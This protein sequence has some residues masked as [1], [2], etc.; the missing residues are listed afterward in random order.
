L[1]DGTP[2]LRAFGQGTAAA[3]DKAI[4]LAAAMSADVMVSQ[5]TRLPA[6]VSST[7]VLEVHGLDFN[8][9]LELEDRLKDME[10]I[11]HLT[12]EAFSDPV[13]TMEVEYDGDAMMLARS[14]SKSGAA[15][16][17]GLKIKGVTKNKITLKKP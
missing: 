10:G 16:D 5:I 6:A 4:S 9:M 2:D 3:L 1:A 14:L 13:K 8:Q 11:A 12:I 17:L 7:I 15:K